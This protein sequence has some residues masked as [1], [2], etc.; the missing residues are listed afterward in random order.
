MGLNEQRLA[1]AR[2]DGS[3][4]VSHDGTQACTVASMSSYIA[5]GGKTTPLETR[6]GGVSSGETSQSTRN[7]SVFQDQPL[8]RDN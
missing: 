4:F 5:V 8:R 7:K 6:Y 1:L 3:T 2:P